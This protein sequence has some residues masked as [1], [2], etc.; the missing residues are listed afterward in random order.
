MRA[1][2]MARPKARIVADRSRGV[3]TMLPRAGGM[4]MARVIA[5]KI[6]GKVVVIK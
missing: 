4:V 2:G 5:S 1:R 3:I 6:L